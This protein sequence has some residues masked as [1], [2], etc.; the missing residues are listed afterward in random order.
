MLDVPAWPEPMLDCHTLG[1]ESQT[2]LLAQLLVVT[3]LV[4]IAR[5]RVHSG[6]SNTVLE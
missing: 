5:L 1:H 6:T 2:T 4:L 3:L